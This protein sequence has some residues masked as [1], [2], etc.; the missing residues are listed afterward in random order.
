MVHM[1]SESFQSGEKLFCL[2]ATDPLLRISILL[3][4]RG[5][6]LEG[7]VYDDCCINTGQHG[8]GFRL[9]RGSDRLYVKKERRRTEQKKEQDS[10]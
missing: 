3:V 1:E 7:G 8:T 10:S 4:K 5:P 9:V 6:N 2:A